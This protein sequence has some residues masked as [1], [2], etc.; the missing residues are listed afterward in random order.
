MG[1]LALARRM[2]PVSIS[3]LNVLKSIS[4][5]PLNVTIPQM[6]SSPSSSTIGVTNDFLPVAAG[7]MIGP[8]AFIG[9]Q[10][11]IDQFNNIDISTL[12]INTQNN[13]STYTSNI[14]FDLANSQS[15][16]LDSIIGA[17][18]DGQMLIIRGGTPDGQPEALTISQ[19][20]NLTIETI[21]GDGSTTVTVT[22]P[23]G[24]GTGLVTGN[25]VNV[26][27]TTSFDA[28]GVEITKL[29]LDSF[30]YQLTSAPN[31][32]ETTG[33]VL[34]GNIQTL[35]GRNIAVTD[36]QSIQSWIVV[37]DSGISNNTV[38]PLS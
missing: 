6:G 31:L 17:A 28:V 16:Q 29:T 9:R 12:G 23:T 19:F 37:F 14:T 36:S 3:S 33:V 5:S 24:T 21:N 2:F 15:S 38:F 26:S 30:T 25:K 4:K 20:L 32:P 27:G 18:F 11:L 34:R 1:S 10:V 8:I 13:E 7:S 35:D 22:L